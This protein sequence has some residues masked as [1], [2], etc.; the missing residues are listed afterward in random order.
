[1]CSS[2]LVQRQP[3]TNTVEIANHIKQLIPT[4]RAQMPPS[5]NLKILFDRSEPIA[6]SVNDVKSTLLLTVALVILVIFLFLRNLSATLIPSLAV[7]IS[8]AGT[9]AAMQLLGYT[10]TTYR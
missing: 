7:P 5:V 3:G 10:W 6:E 8:I 1:M 9:F 2:D 4:F